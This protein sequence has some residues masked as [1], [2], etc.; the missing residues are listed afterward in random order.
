VRE[1]FEIGPDGEVLL[2]QAAET[3]DR[4]AEC[5]ERIAADGIMLPLRGGGTKMHPL[6]RVVTDSRALL[7]R[8]LKEL[9]LEDTE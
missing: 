2:E 5:E 4:I 1:R 6:V 7:L 9:G 8:Y 3:L